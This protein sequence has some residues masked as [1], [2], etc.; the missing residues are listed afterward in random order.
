MRVKALL[1]DFDGIVV[2]TEV[3]ALSAWQETYEE[4][5]QVLT[6]DAWSACVGT[7]GGFEPLDHLEELLGRP[8]E[9]RT[10]VDAARK[11]RET[12][13]VSSE[14]LRPGVDDY[15]VRAR[16]LGL[17][18]AIVSSGAARW[19]ASHLERLDRS[20]GWACINCADGDASRA[21]PL[22]CLYEETLGTLGI[23][24]DEAVAFEDSPNGIAAAKAAGIFCVAVP[25]PV[26]RSLDLSAADLRLDSFEALPL[27]DVLARAQRGG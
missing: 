6:I 15:F 9:D 22:P 7:L 14:P 8:L 10:A 19:I 17:E 13:L 23:E 27:D 4:H 21:K 5:G 25:N 12:E 20:A 1:F 16:E 3:P 2:D 11:A 26:T 18:V 24:P